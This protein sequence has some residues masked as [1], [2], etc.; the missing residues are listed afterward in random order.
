[1]LE[2]YLG[3]KIENKEKKFKEVLEIHHKYGN[4]FPTKPEYK[5]DGSLKGHIELILSADKSQYFR[6][7]LSTREYAYIE[8]Y[9]SC[10]ENQE[11]RSSSSPSKSVISNEPSDS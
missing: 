1:M 3:E 6:F 4:D 8:G 9:L 11:D 2:A 5:K 7:P 10:L